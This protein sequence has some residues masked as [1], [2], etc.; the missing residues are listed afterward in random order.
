MINLLNEGVQLIHIGP[1][2]NIN[3]EMIK[4]AMVM[5]RS[6]KQYAKFYTDKYYITISFHKDNTFSISHNI[7]NVQFYREFTRL[8]CNLNCSTNISLTAQFIYRWMNNLRKPLYNY[9]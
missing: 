9:N 8:Q 4:R 6:S 3:L 2:T 5:A 7:R 1:T